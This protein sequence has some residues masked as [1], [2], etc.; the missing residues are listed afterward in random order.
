MEEQKSNIKKNTN[1]NCVY[2]FSI[3]KYCPD[4]YQCLIFSIKQVNAVGS[5][6]SIVSLCTLH[7]HEHV[8]NTPLAVHYD[9]SYICINSQT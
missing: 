7:Y 1:T 3:Y 9:L 8:H 6:R 5:L 2:A 4:I